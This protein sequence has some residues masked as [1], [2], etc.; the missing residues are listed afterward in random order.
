MQPWG[1]SDANANA[2]L[3]KKTPLKCQYKTINARSLARSQ[4][5]KPSAK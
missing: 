2:M 3:K 5:F 1:M 4:K